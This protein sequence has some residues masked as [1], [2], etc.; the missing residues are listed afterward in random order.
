MTQRERKSREALSCYAAASKLD[1]LIVIGMAVG[2][3]I[4]AVISAMA[5]KSIVDQQWKDKLSANVTEHEAGGEV[6]HE[7]LNNLSSMRV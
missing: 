3:M 5:T 2:L 7:R 1:R 6:T 4:G